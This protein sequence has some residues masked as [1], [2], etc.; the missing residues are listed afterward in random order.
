MWNNMKKYAVRSIISQVQIP[1][2]I[3]E[4]LHLSE[5]ASSL[6]SLL[7]KW[8]SLPYWHTQMIAMID[9]P[10]LGTIIQK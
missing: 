7:W 8:K 1:K 2:A 4:H 3:L 6:E 5:G 9:S 10:M